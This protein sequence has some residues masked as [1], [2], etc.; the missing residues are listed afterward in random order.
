[1]KTRPREN[2]SKD[3]FI[4]ILHKLH[5]FDVTVLPGNMLHIQNKGKESIEKEK[6]A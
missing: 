5:W 3:I 2:T 1:M 4:T 6:Q